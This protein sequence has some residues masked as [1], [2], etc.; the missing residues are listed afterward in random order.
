MK[1][2]PEKRLVL[3]DIAMP[4]DIDPAVAEIPHV[5]LFDMD[6]LNA[7]LEDS[8]ARRINEIP[9]V[10]QIL[11]EELVQFEIHLKS[12]EMLPIIADIHQQAEEIRI[13]ELEKTLRRLPRLTDAERER[14]ELLTQSLVRKLL[15]QPTRRLRV[16]AT[17]HRATEYA[18][19][20]RTLFNLTDETIA[21]SSPGS[22]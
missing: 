10:K 20:A 21:S 6:G 22:D 3:I 7:Q 16:E 18:A 8:V 11:Q 14:I 15:D 5:T 1:V 4:R 17:S 12:L 13:I 9:H 2:R 19:L